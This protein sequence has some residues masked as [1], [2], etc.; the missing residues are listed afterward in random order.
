MTAARHQLNVPATL[1]ERLFASPTGLI[2]TYPDETW[3]PDVS[4]VAASIGLHARAT[5]T[6]SAN[7]RP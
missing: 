7:D 6:E 2:E 5:G 4:A 1:A 3:P